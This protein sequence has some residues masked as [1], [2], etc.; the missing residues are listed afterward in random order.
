MSRKLSIQ[1][2]EDRR[3]YVIDFDDP[4]AI[5]VAPLADPYE[6]VGLLAIA[7]DGDPNPPFV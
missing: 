4:A 2:L 1:R 6:G 5:V 3:M 7:L